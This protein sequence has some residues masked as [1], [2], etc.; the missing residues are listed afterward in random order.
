[1]GRL[2]EEAARLAAIFQRATPRSLVL[3]NE[4][5]AGTA[6]HEAE[7]LARDAVRGLRLLGA[8]AVYVT[9]LHDL[10]LAVDELNATTP[11][12]SLVGSL[13]ADAE[14]EE[15]SAADPEH[16]RTFRIH[17][18]I[19]RGRSYASDIARRY[20]ISF[21]QLTRLLQERGISATVTPDDVPGGG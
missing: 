11:G 9:H 12:T 20:G 19:P 5:L 3:L 1:M 2:D 4:T 10:A 18:G 21:A 8:R 14:D 7:A 15:P 16:R 17:P 13:V 6:A